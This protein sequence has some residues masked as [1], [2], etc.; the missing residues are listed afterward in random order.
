MTTVINILAGPGCGKST[1]AAD[2]Y[3]T[4]SKA[5]ESV[6]LTREPAKLWAW[7]DQRPRFEDQVLIM[8][9]QF[10]QEG[11]LYGKVDYVVND[12]GGALSCGFYADYYA[13][14]YPGCQGQG[15]TTMHTEL[16]LA[17]YERAAQLYDLKFVTFL[18]PRKF[19]Y[20]QGGRFQT[21]EHSE[22]ID[23]AIIQWCGRN[24]IRT[25]TLMCPPRYRVTTI[26]EVLKMIDGPTPVR[27]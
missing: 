26:L 19:D 16:A 15:P 5:G 23:Q 11:M 21:E 27:A 22:Q 2:L 18:L 4:L 9:Q 13:D 1:T 24:S 14:Y 3:V 25:H 7:Q 6:E 10:Q 17:F 8:G 12:S 20:V